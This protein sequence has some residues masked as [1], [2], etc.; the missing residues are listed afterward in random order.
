MTNSTKILNQ[1]LEIILN[2]GLILYI[3]QM[4]HKKMEYGI[5]SSIWQWIVHNNIKPM[6]WIADHFI[7]L[8]FIIL[9][10]ARAFIVF[11]LIS[12]FGMGRV[13]T[14]DTGWFLGGM[15]TIVCMFVL[16]I[17]RFQLEEYTSYS[18]ISTSLRHLIHKRKMKKKTRITS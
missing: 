15:T 17:E 14:K 13:T 18:K 4:V 7:Y 6:Q 5:F 8:V 12:D 3:V 16:T 10:F 11:E 1:L 9:A 2:M